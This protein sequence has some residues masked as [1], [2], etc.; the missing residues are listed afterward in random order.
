MVE[1]C[2]GI[3]KFINYEIFLLA[4]TGVV[5]FLWVDWMV[6]SRKQKTG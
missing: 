2:G 4:L 1:Y 5:S 6:Q 3:A